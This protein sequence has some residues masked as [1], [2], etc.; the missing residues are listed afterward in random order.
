MLL[1]ARARMRE[2]ALSAHAPAQACADAQADYPLPYWPGV[3][4]SHMAM[5]VFEVCWPTLCAALA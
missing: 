3:I 1:P 4:V 5:A 2:A